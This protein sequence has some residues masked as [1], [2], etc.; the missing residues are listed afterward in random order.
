MHATDLVGINGITRV[1][2]VYTQTLIIPVIS[3]NISKTGRLRQS[4]PSFV[5]MPFACFISEST[6]R[7]LVEVGTGGLTPK[8]SWWPNVWS[9]SV[10]MW[11]S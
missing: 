1:L 3:N 10:N 2:L 6:G 7:I 5:I 8:L 9:V 4:S 11:F